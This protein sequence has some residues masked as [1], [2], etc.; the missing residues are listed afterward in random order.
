MGAYSAE[1]SQKLVLT[2]NLCL[3]LMKNRMEKILPKYLRGATHT[4]K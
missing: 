2:N 3:K 4:Q 1:T